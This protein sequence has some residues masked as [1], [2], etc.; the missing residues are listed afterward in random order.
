MQGFF[1][2][3]LHNYIN[4]IYFFTKFLDFCFFLTIVASGFVIFI[5]ME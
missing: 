1:S 4:V 5:A 3:I 2:N